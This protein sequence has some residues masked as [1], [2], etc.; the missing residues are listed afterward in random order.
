MDKVLAPVYGVKKGAIVSLFYRQNGTGEKSCHE[1]M[2]VENP[3]G[4]ASEEVH[5]MQN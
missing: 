5:V 4:Q 1:K 3:V 2:G